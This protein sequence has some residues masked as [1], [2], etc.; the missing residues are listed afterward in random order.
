MSEM[1]VTSLLQEKVDLQLHQAVDRDLINPLPDLRAI[2]EYQMGW[3]EAADSP[4]RGKRLRPLILLLS[5]YAAGAFWEPALPAA[6][7]V[8]L[9]HNFTLI[10]DDIQDSSL[11]RRGKPTVWT[12]W[13]VA[14]AINA[15]DCMMGLAQLSLLELAKEYPP[16]QVTQ[17]AE[18]FNRTFVELTRGQYLDLAYEVEDAIPVEKYQWMVD[19]KTGALISACMEIGAILGGASR[20]L[21]DQMA[22]FG[23]KVGRAFQ[24]QDDWL[25]IWG[26]DQITGKSNMSDLLERK[27]SYPVVLGIDA[28]GAFASEWM[29]VDKIDPVEATRLADLLVHEGIKNMTED[30]FAHEY[31]S[32]LDLYSRIDFAPDRKQ[33]LMELVQSMLTRLK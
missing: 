12:K 9:L 14:Q 22:L 32:A 4:A 26:I 5:T 29:R 15:G 1:P 30:A 16:E 13:G 24:I 6:A 18:L 21:V 3:D 2:L 20:Q 8:E 10:H 31:A 19:G 11:L 28:K 25:G 33:A 7:A 23:R 17:V 27:K